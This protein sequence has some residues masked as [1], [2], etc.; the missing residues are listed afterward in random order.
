VC[1]CGKN[2]E[3]LSCEWV[4]E[5]TKKEEQMVKEGVFVFFF[6]KRT[7]LHSKRVGQI[8]KHFRI[9]R[10]RKRERRHDTNP[11]IKTVT[12]CNKESQEKMI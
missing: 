7:S 4:C 3:K 5:K 6:E 12:P 8:T 2:E 11:H 1:A 9:R 10:E